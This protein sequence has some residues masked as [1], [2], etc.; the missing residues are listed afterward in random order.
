[1]GCHQ[2]HIRRPHAGQLLYAAAN[3]ALPFELLTWAAMCNRGVRIPRTAVSGDVVRTREPWLL[4]SAQWRDK[5]DGVV[6][7]LL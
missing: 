5:A 7:L 4:L 2:R 1:M 6:M 3:A